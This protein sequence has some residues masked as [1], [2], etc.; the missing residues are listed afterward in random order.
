LKRGI[1]G[2]FSSPFSPKKKATK[3]T[4]PIWEE[5][6]FVALLN[7]PVNGIPKKAGVWLTERMYGLLQTAELPQSNGFC[8]FIV[9]IFTQ[10]CQK[11]QAIFPKGSTLTNNA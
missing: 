8:R 9:N 6:A 11:G 5:N 4:L 1:E 3:G 10:I 2:D 7:D